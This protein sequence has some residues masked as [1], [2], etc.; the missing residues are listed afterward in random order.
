MCTKPCLG[1]IISRSTKR[2]T[3]Y[4]ILPNHWYITLS[5]HEITWVCCN[6]KKKYGKFIMWYFVNKESVLFGIA[7]LS[8]VQCIYILLN[9]VG[10]H[11]QNFINITKMPSMLYYYIHALIYNYVPRYWQSTL[12]IFNNRT[13]FILLG[14]FVLFTFGYIYLKYLKSL[15]LR[16]KF[17]PSIWNNM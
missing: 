8:C 16:E 17:K 2:M 12:A 15:P 13:V 7:F 10:S 3:E 4:R 14:R 11:A 5:T 1:P 6:L 9:K